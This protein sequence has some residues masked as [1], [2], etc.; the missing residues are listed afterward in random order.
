MKFLHFL[1]VP[2]RVGCER[3]E[4]S[5]DIDKADRLLSSV[6]CFLF[7]H[8][9]HWRRRRRSNRIADIYLTLR[10]LRSNNLLFDNM[11]FVLFI[12]LRSIYSTERKRERQLTRSSSP[13]RT[14]E[15]DFSVFV[16]EA[17][18]K[19]H[20]LPPRWKKQMFIH[21]VDDHIQQYFGFFTSFSSLGSIA[22]CSLDK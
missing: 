21:I 9:R 1:N 12:E 18:R 2:P 15:S 16:R 7:A 11:R 22:S 20:R 10:N 4:N 13:L 5:S 17:S 19:K 14:V 3:E 6:S 8:H